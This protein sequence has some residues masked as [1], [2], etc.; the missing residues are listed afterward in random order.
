MTNPTPD[1][2]LLWAEKR[3]TVGRNLNWTT[4]GVIEAFRAGQSR[5]DAGLLAALEAVLTEADTITM[6]MRRRK[7]FDAAR[8]AIAAAKGV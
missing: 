7:I 5:A 8:A 1:D 3:S 6:T 4:T 2:A